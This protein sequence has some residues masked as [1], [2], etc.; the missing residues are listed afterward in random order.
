M[1]MSV[2]CFFCL[3]LPLRKNLLGNVSKHKAI[4]IFGGIFGWQEDVMQE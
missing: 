2:A 1:F 3:T 4:K